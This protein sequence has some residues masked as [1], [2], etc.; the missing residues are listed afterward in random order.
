[1]TEPWEGLTEG[2]AGSLQVAGR[3]MHAESPKLPSVPKACLL[4]L[5]SGTLPHTGPV[6]LCHQGLGAWGPP[7]RVLHV[8]DSHP[9]SALGSPP[10]SSLVHKS[11]RL[12]SPR[13]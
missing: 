8:R 6:V 2:A 12:L 5:L 10:A 7:Q 4:S 1:M 13:L 9:F 3:E 11:R